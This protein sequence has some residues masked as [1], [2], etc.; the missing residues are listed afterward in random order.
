[1]IIVAQVIFMILVVAMFVFFL[2]KTSSRR[3]ALKKILMTAVMA[4]AVVFI[5][6]PSLAD[7]AAHLL[8]IGRGADLLFYT[9][10]LVLLF[11]LLD[12]SIRKKEEKKLQSKLIRKIALL[13]K[14]L[15]ILEGA[16]KQK[17]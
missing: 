4:M 15:E 12:N 1:M 11:S 10:T 2:G 5:T 7:E 6:N 9:T 16:K 14:R 8:G 17:S 13:D 3:S